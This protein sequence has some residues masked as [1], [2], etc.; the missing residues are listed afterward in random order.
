MNEAIAKAG[1]QTHIPLAD[2]I[3]MLLQPI[4]SHHRV[5]SFDDYRIVPKCAFIGG[6]PP[7]CRSG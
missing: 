1:I 7:N 6:Q 2:R 5:I 4:D 3:S